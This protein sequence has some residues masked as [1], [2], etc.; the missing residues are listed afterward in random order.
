[1]AQMSFDDFISTGYTFP[2]TGG[3]LVLTIDYNQD[4][5]VFEISA[6]SSYNVAS[7]TATEDGEDVEVI[8]TEPGVDY[9][10]VFNMGWE[11]V[12]ITIEVGTSPETTDNENA[13]WIYYENDLGEGGS[14]DIGQEGYVPPIVWDDGQHKIYRSGNQVMKMYRSGELIYQRLNPPTV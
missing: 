13:Y 8:E 1:M 10:M 3:T 6:S 11:Y 9:Y 4:I 12:E 2:G 5:K 14:F 7:I